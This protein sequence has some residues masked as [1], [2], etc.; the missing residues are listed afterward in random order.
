MIQ[1]ETDRLIIRRFM[2]DDWKDSYHYAMLSSE[3]KS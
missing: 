1:M 3:W 2:P